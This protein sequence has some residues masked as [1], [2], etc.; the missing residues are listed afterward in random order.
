MTTEAASHQPTR[1]SESTK[2]F[3][4]KACAAIACAMIALVGCEKASP[5]GAVRG[6][7]TTRGEK[8]PGGQVC[9]ISKAGVG[10]VAAVAADGTYSFE[11]RLPVGEYTA[12]LML[13]PPP[14]PGEASPSSGIAE[15]TW[16]RLV[17]AAYRAQTSSP[18]RFVVKPVANEIPIEIT[19]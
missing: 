12:W 17:P 15:S 4:K 16:H 6:T 14:P 7:V 13:P 3:R 19:D 18:L 11:D 9:V 10:A 8:L 2:M 1:F 5:T